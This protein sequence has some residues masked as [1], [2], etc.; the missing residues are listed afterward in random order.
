MSADT[1]LKRYSA[2]NIA[3]PWRGLNVVPDVTIPEG[4]R[5]AVMFLYSGIAADAPAAP[6]ITF[7]PE[8]GGGGAWGRWSGI[9][10]RR[11]QKRALAQEDQELI[12]II[13]EAA[14]HLMQH[15]KKPD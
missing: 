11:Q 6:P 15:K 10:K 7:P 12:A 14:P 8:M 13:K 4:E 9:L 1:A 3:S 5:Y 2:L